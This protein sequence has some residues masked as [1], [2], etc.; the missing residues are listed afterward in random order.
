MNYYISHSIE[1][2]TKKNA[3]AKAPSD[4]YRMCKCMGWTQYDMTT[5]FRNSNIVQY[6]VESIY[7]GINQWSS[8]KR[9]K[10]EF[11]LYQHPM[12]WGN[13]GELIAASSI[14]NLKRNRVDTITLI[15]DLECLRQKENENLSDDKKK[16]LLRIELK[17][18]NA[19]S[20][21]IS[22]NKY[23][24]NFLISQGIESKKIVTLGIFDYLCDEPQYVESSEF[25]IAIAG[26]LSQEKC[27]YIYNLAQNNSNIKIA[28]YGVG[29]DERKMKN[30]MIYKGSFAPEVLPQ[31]LDARYGLVWD[32]PEIT[33]CCGNFGGYLRYNN[34][35]KFSLY[36][37]A[38][39][40]VITWSKAA[41]ADFVIKNNV[42]I[43]VDDLCD[44]R[45][46]LDRI[47]DSQY[48]N[49][50]KNAQEIG[51]KVRDGYYFKT[52]LS[53]AKKLCKSNIKYD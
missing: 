1:K 15:H 14:S 9:K 13:V 41:I 19:S 4:I 24:S 23:M 27:G 33:A 36:M 16:Q 49:M 45:N 52:A 11:V 2:D 44:L 21:I 10:S 29:L 46:A 20:I 26:N 51:R 47:T 17:I 3:A 38:G 40:P 7:T 50:R 6:M 34:P 39:I 31:N 8:L 48:H 5:P 12:Y 28:L 35:H 32:G 18:L 37:A 25:D 42:G 30:N 53:K 43:I 22:H